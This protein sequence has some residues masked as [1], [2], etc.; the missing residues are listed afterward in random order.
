M[1]FPAALGEGQ[2]TWST[3]SAYIPSDSPA[4]LRTR[5]DLPSLPEATSALYRH[6]TTQDARCKPEGPPASPSRI[7]RPSGWT[8]TYAA[9]PPCGNTAQAWQAGGLRVLCGSVFP[10]GLGTIKAAVVL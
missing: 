6:R 7:L 5:V 1:V 9:D 8:V 10:T 2:E 3:P 4:G